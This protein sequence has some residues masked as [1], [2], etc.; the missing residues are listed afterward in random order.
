METSRIYKI[1]IG[2]A[3]LVLLILL[4]LVFLQ[5]RKATEN[6]NNAQPIDNSQNNT[7]QNN[8]NQTRLDPKNIP[9]SSTIIIPISNND[10]VEVRNFIKNSDKVEENR[11]G[12]IDGDSFGIAYSLPDST[13]YITISAE[14][15]QEADKI[16]VQA[17]AQFLNKLSI[18]K[19][20]ACRLSVQTNFLLVDQRVV[21]RETLPLSFCK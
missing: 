12:I 20:Q 2:V 17:E 11:V 7:S 5:N 6:N 21:D 3:I 10:G 13:F 9:N 4:V 18:G 16:R 1:L 8:G 14:D 19:E 15:Q